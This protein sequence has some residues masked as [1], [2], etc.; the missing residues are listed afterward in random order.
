VTGN[1]GCNSCDQR[2]TG[3]GLCHCKTC[4]LT[5]T[6]YLAFD[7]H[8]AQDRCVNVETAISRNGKP[9]FEVHHTTLGKRVALWNAPDSKAR[10]AERV[11]KLKGEEKKAK[12]GEQLVGLDWFGE[13]AESADG[14]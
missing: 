1:W 4:H 11:A 6:G 10:N 8:R 5:F 2:W 12:F 13:S 7:K 9:V 14:S 3:L